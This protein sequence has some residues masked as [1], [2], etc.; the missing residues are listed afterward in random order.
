MILDVFDLKT[1]QCRQLPL[2]ANG[3]RALHG[4][5]ANNTAMVALPGESVGGCLLCMGYA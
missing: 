2:A 1:K 3:H 5:T 4:V